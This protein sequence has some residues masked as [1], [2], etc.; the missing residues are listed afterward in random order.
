MDPHRWK[1]RPLPARREQTTGS[2]SAS[3]HRLQRPARR[4]HRGLG[5]ARVQRH[6][7][8]PARAPRSAA[9]AFR[10]GQREESA[11]S[12][13][14]PA[15]A[16]PFGDETVYLTRN[17]F[18]QRED[19]SL[20]AVT[21]TRLRIPGSRKKKPDMHDPTKPPTFGKKLRN[22]RTNHPGDLNQAAMC[23]L[24]FGED[25]ISQNKWSSW[26][27][28]KTLPDANEIAALARFFKVSAD[29]LCGLT[30]EASGLRPLSWIVDQRILDDFE[31]AESLRDVAKHIK[32]IA[33]GEV[34][35]F[36]SQVPV[37]ARVVEGDEAEKL[38]A[39]LDK[40][41]REL[42]GGKGRTP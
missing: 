4:R 5:P 1:K 28:D 12:D 38:R 23:A 27:T 22:L 36:R 17:R 10:I 33:P 21:S 34:V 29:Y 30:A 24:V 9:P 25:A 42:R 35:N 14:A 2:G 32:K 18:C 6:R 37:G 39:K 41:M 19:A 16:R 8:S 20:R 26:E 31:H 15:R 7:T 40:R 11:A 3:C 13:F